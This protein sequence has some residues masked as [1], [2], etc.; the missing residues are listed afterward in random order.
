LTLAGC[1]GGG[2]GGNKNPAASV[3]TKIAPVLTGTWKLVN[4]SPPSSSEQ[5]PAN[6]NS[7]TGDTE[8]L[9]KVN[10]N[11]ASK[12]VTVSFDSEG[13]Y[14]GEI[15]SISSNNETSEYKTA[16]DGA[17]HPDLDL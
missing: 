3:Y 14:T 5:T 11:S 13:N 16:D 10:A 1:G 9:W 12:T 2:G 4:M 8:T 6:L 15:Y 7:E 17:D